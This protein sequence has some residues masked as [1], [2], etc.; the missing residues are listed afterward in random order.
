MPN[1][2]LPIGFSLKKKR[3][4]IVGGGNVALRKIETLFDYDTNITVIAPKPTDKIEYYSER[5]LLKLEKREYVVGEASKFGLVIAASD[6]AD[7]NM[8]VADDCNKAGIPINVVDRPGL[9]DFIFPAT[10]LRDCLTVSVLT[11]GKAPFLSGQ[12]RMILEDIFPSRWNKIAKLATRFRKKVHKRW[13]GNPVEKAGCFERFVGADWKKLLKDLS[14]DE[15]DSEL[16]KML[17]N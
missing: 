11:D 1:E 15:I 14:D 5:E 7:V 9:C 6:N 3:C 13:K 16:D 17:E 2:Y 4:L 8:T 10:I 12:L